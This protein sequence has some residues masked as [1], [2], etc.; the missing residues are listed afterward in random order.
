[1]DDDITKLIDTNRGMETSRNPNP[2]ISVV[3]P[4]YNRAHV[5]GRAIRSVLTQTFPDFECIVV[6]DRSTDGTIELV[7][8]LRDPRIRV[9]RLATNCGASRARNEGIQAARGEFVAFL[10]SDDEWLPRKLELQVARL[11]EG[12]DPQTAVVYCQ[13]RLSGELVNTRVLRPHRIHEGDAFIHLLIGWHPGTTSTIM[14]KRSSLLEIGG[15]DEGLACAEDY[16]LWLRLAQAANHFAAVSEVLLVKYEGG[17][18]QLKSDARARLRSM[19]LFDRKWRRVITD[20]LGAGAYRRWKARLYGNIQNRQFKL[21]RQAV[22][23]GERMAAWRCWLA[24]CRLLPWSRKKVM[25]ALVLVT[26]GEGPY[27]V[28]ARAKEAILRRVRVR[29]AWSR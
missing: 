26:L 18:L 19:E 29:R 24:M 20:H 23:H 3:I 17:A 10:D 9:L 15:F 2:L 8:G 14:V 13:A 1:M 12:A 11:R 7:E 21:V 27:G 6:D 22:A 4:T 25:Q 16:D 28:L 5:L